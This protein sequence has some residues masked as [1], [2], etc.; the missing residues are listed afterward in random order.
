MKYPLNKPLSGD[1]M[2]CRICGCTEHRACIVREESGRAIGACSWVKEPPYTF[3]LMGPLCSEC[4]GTALDL[5]YFS[6]RL[7]KLLK[8]A[9][10]AFGSVGRLRVTYLL[11]AAARRAEKRHQEENQQ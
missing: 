6:R 7:A 3:E 1:G 8:R 10:L 5:A 2:C 11:E 4:A 9:G